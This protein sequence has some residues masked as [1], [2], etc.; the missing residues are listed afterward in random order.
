L[1]VKV[2]NLSFVANA[3]LHLRLT[4]NTSNTTT[5]IITEIRTYN[6]S[7]RQ[8]RIISVY[9]GIFEGLKIDYLKDF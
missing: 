4:L 8:T 2:A 9:T 1:I 6:N 5:R 3:M 7:D